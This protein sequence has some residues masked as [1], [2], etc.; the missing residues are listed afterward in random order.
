LA[1]VFGIQAGIR[2][3][4]WTANRWGWGLATEGSFSAGSTSVIAA[5]P[6]ASLALGGLATV[7]GRYDEADAYF[8]RSAAMSDNMGAKFSATTTDLY[9][10]R[11]LAERQAPGDSEGK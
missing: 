8:A 6:P 7:L 2:S 1:V 10:G 9:W 5:G 11:M 4:F 3:A